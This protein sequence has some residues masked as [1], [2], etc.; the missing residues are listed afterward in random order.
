MTT[1]LCDSIAADAWRTSLQWK[2]YDRIVVLTDANVY[3]EVF[4]V[5][6]WLNEFPIHVIPAGENAKGWEQVERIYQKLHDFKC[7]RSSLLLCVGGGLVTDLGGFCASTYMRGIDVVHVPTT[8]LAMVDA[9]IGG[10]TGYNTSWGKNMIGTFHAPKAVWLYPDV[11][12]TLDQR[13]FYSGMAEA[14]KT[15]IMLDGALWIALRSNPL[16]N[17]WM[18]RTAAAK[19][20]LVETD[21]K[22]KGVRAWLNFGHTI[23][24]A[25]EHFLLSNKQDSLLHGE[26][27]AWGMLL[28]L[29]VVYRDIHPVFNEL[30]DLV[31]KHIPAPKLQVEDIPAIL[32]RMQADKKNAHQ[33]LVLA[34]PLGEGVGGQVVEVKVKV[35]EEIL[36]RWINR[37]K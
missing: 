35:V 27:I 5:L 13:E 7:T 4:P 31:E 32:E 17:N 28:E 30:R 23:G 10:K 14:W 26:A 2:A 18:H 22:E 29:N 9:A 11:L 19:R 24:H 8:V 25:L 20:D 15:A 6:E 16:P 37:W 1:I 36:L 3:R 33:K 12:K 34:V 21:F